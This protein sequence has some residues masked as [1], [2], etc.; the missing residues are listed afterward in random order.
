MIRILFAKFKELGPLR[1]AGAAYRYGLNS[2]L[3]KIHGFDPWHVHGNYYSRPYKARVIALAD[4]CAPNVLV[5]IGAGLG[6]IVG[7][8]KAQIRIGLDLD[9]RVI[10]AARY[11]VPRDVYLAVADFLQPET[12]ITAL[13]SA[14]QNGPTIKTID[15]LVLVNWIH[16]VDIDKI[17]QSIEQI[18][19]DYPVR[20]ILVDAIRPNLAGYRH[21]HDR[22]AFARLGSI[23]SEMPGDAARDLILIRR[24]KI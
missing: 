6:D 8:A 1:L 15:C 11:C 20:H 14:E 16:T 5:E 12:V 24:P 9:P 19:A 7:R 4:Q 23:E 18:A 17:A 3:Q 21:H 10:A 13:K 2:I 22:S